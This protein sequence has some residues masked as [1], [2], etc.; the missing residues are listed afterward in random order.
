MRTRYFVLHRP[1]PPHAQA[2][3]PADAARVA[4]FLRAAL[5]SRSGL[6]ATALYGKPDVRAI[7]F[8]SED[9]YH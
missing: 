5:G 3:V 4:A 8:R 6:R 2:D 9:A 7:P 1:Y